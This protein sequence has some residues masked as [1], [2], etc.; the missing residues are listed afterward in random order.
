MLNREQLKQLRREIVLDSLYY[1]D[2]E[3]SFGINKY[4]VYYFFEGYAEYL[5]EL[6]KEEIKDFDG[7]YHG[8]LAEYDT[9][10][11]LESYYYMY[12]GDPLPIKREHQG[13]N[14]QPLHQVQVRRVGETLER[15]L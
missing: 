13:L 10:D 14:H 7:D 6:M 11:N 2:Y 3:N 5:Y 4:N 8:H 1:D 12:D 15:L 9:S